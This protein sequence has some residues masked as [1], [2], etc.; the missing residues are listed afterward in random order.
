M[1][2]IY[3]ECP[4]EA[5]YVGLVFRPSC[6]IKSTNEKTDPREG[7]HRKPTGSSAHNLRVNL[8]NMLN[9]LLTN[10]WAPSHTYEEARWALPV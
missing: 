9:I 5:G 2:I 6:T 3:R 4:G 10:R 7:N 1:C 8:G